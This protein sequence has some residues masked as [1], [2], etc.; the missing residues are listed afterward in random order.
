MKSDLKLS[1]KFTGSSSISF[2]TV[3][4]QLQLPG[5]KGCAFIL[6]ARL[7]ATQFT[8]GQQLALKM[9]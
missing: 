7:D 3:I 5:D 6:K 1:F 8:H 2:S 9:G 4:G